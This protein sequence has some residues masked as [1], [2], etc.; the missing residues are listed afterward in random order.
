[1]TRPDTSRNQAV[2][3]FC[4]LMIAGSMVSC[5]AL[6]AARPEVTIQLAT[7]PR[8][9]ILPAGS[10]LL[11][12]A[13][14]ASSHALKNV[15]FFLDSQCVGTVSKPPYRLIATVP[16]V[17]SFS[18]TAKATTAA[19]IAASDSMEVTVGNLAKR[20]LDA[21]DAAALMIGGP[22]TLVD[23]SD[24]PS[25]TVALTDAVVRLSASATI[26]AAN[27]ALSNRNITSLELFVNDKLVGTTTKHKWSLGYRFA[28][29]GDYRITAVATDS[30]GRRVTSIPV[31]IRVKTPKHEAR[32]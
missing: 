2:S 26:V 17:P 23:I 27:P 3:T 13:D 9:L 29:A 20:E 12:S 28:K 32:R 7:P 18:I 1:M 21:E 14:V 15:A 30:A 19:G 11:I 10:R 22:T 6:F 31:A 25:G 16:N 4:F 5:G 24:P 8:T